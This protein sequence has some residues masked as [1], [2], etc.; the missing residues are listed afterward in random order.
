MVTV[1]GF[2]TA[3]SFFKGAATQI[4]HREQEEK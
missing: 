3:L 1:K 2:C 4:W